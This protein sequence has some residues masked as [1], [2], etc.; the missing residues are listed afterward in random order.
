MPA[1]ATAAPKPSAVAQ[2]SAVASRSAVKTAA[3]VE[4]KSAGRRETAPPLPSFARAALSSAPLHPLK[5]ALVSE[6]SHERGGAGRTELDRVA[7]TPVATANHLHPMTAD[8]PKLA[9]PVPAKTPSLGGGQPMP[10]HIQ[11]A[12]QSSLMVDL[13]SVR[14]HASTAAQRKAHALSARAFTFGNDIFLGHG[15]HPTDLTLISHE[16]AHVIQQQGHAP[17]MQAWSSDRSQR[18]EREADMAAS[19]V[20]RGERFAVRERVES[21]RVQRLGISD[22]LDYLAD[23]AYN[24]PGFRMFTIVLGVNPINMEHV[25]R[26]AANVL[27]AVVEFIP[28]G[29]LI[30]QALDKYGVFDKVGNWMS[31]Q[32]E[33]L[34]MIGSSIKDALMDFLDSLSWRDIFHLGSVWDRAKKIFTDPIDRIIDFVGGLLEG[35]WKFVRDVILKPIARLA[36]GRRGWNLLCAVIGSNPITGE[37]VPQ[38]PEALI[39]GF[40]ELIGQEEVW[41]NIKKANAITRAFNWFKGVLSGV[42]NF[43]AQIPD[44]FVKALKS[45]EWSDI[46][47]LPAGFMK[48][49]GVF[50][51]FAGDFISWGLGKVFDLLQIIFE[52]VAPSVMPYLRKV[53]AAFQKII[54]DPIGF[55]RHLVATAK[56]GLHLFMEHFGAHLKAALLDWL[57]GSLPGVYIPKAM[58]LSEMGLFA[59]SVLGITWAQIRAKIVKALGENGERIMVGLETTLDIVM[60]LVKGGPAAAWDLIKEKLTNLKDL[61]VNG[62]VSFVVDTIIKKAIPKLISMFIPGAGFISAIISV[63]DTIMV[64]VHKLAKIA[65]AVKA[66]VDSIVA[67]AGGQIEAAALRVESGL[68][69]MLAIAISFLAGFL[70]LGNI[71]SKVLDVIKKLQDMIDKALEAGVNWIVGKAKSLFAK[72]FGGREKEKPG[73]ASGDV[74]AQA[75]AALASQLKADHTK[76]EAQAIVAQILKDLGPRGLKSL[77]IGP[78]NEDGIAM[79]E[80]EASPKLPLFKLVLKGLIPRGRTVRMVVQLELSATY[81][82]PLEPAPIETADRAATTLTGGAEFKPKTPRRSAAFMAPAANVLTLVT[83]NT[84]NNS[85]NQTGNSGHAE[86][87]FVNWLEG[88]GSKYLGQIKRVTINISPY[89]PCTVCAEDLTSAL[90]LIKKADNTR[91]VDASLVW[92]EAYP[93][94]RFGRQATTSQSL[95]ELQSAGWKLMGG[96]IVDDRSIHKNMVHVEPLK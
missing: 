67:I 36:E 66:F 57:T 73:E 46:L 1:A 85:L 91:A 58:S 6:P 42:L 82:P 88:K 69:S 54:R 41:E 32:I 27:R 89:S 87:Q 71:A 81:A 22:A 75:A 25:D 78:E 4:S 61:V 72:L 79:I 37:T 49:V 70:G 83:W 45:L 60:A 35:I 96:S 55:V 24:I 30:E 8:K 17:M 95:L 59:M 16:A 74:R 31:D 53:G 77:S 13:S 90:N 26:N 63:Y 7:H 10:V 39:G 65:Q 29:H 92:V 23:K 76:E 93:G 64:F 34:G 56:L 94:D 48:I 28:G 9:P 43:V 50:G 38:T 5:P 47:D 52:V 80:A 44:L 51:K 11:H 68:E 12:I 62:I 3:P 15:E 2:R 33:K 21:P 40:M 20:T 19:A 14:L 86:H 18:C 84:S